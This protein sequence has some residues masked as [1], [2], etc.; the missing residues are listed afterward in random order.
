MQSKA[1]KLNNISEEH[2]VE[3]ASCC[4]TESKKLMGKLV[5]MDF[6]LFAV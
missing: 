2:A 1:T 5:K 3:D 6:I 4:E